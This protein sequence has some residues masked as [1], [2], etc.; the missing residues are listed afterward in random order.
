MDAHVF[1]IKVFRIITHLKG[2]VKRRCLFPPLLSVYCTTCL[3]V[4]QRFWYPFR[5]HFILLSPLH[6]QIPE[7]ARAS[8]RSSTQ[9]PLLGDAALNA[10][11][12]SVRLSSLL[13]LCLFCCGYHFAWHEGVQW[14]FS[15]ATRYSN[16]WSLQWREVIQLNR[17]LV[18]F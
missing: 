1:K 3:C 10:C 8:V 18:K 9:I 7:P 5:T 4:V 13:L 12:L 16:A 15:Y 11:A 17:N 6:S 2:F 14:K